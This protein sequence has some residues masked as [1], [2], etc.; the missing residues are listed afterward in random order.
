VEY[1]SDSPLQVMVLVLL[2][3][4]EVFVS[5]GPFQPSLTFEGRPKPTR[6]E[7]SRVGTNIGL[8]WKRLPGANT[9]AYYEQSQ[10][11]VAKSF[12]TL[13][14]GIHKF[15]YKFLTLIIWLEGLYHKSEEG[16]FSC[17]LLVNAPLG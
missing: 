4:I 12:I 7:Y 11:S 14:S 2:R 8:S 10:I 15:T 5:S 3:N 13:G 17:L 16:S 6:G 1:L 9:L